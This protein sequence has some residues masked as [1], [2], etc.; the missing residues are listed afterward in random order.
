[1]LQPAARRRARALRPG[2]TRGPGGEPDVRE[3]IRAGKPL[4]DFSASDAYQASVVIRGEIESPAFVRYLERLGQEQLASFTAHD[5][6]VLDSLRRD[7]PVADSLRPRLPRL[8]DMGAV[9]RIGS[10]RGVRYLLSRSL[11]AEIGERGTHTRRR[12]LDRETNKELILRHLRDA[13]EKGAP[14]SELVQ[15]LPQLSR[16]S[17]GTLLEELRGEGRARLDGAR[18]TARWFPDT[19]F[20]KKTPE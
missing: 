3:A 1:M 4:P 11:Y 17:V 14:M 13:G 8:V 7:E 6:L 2:R 18:R 5:L 10:G 19:A 20:S 9:E 16:R 15:V 12:G